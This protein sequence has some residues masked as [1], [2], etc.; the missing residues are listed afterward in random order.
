MDALGQE[1]KKDVVGCEK[2][3]ELQAS[4][5]PEMSEWGNPAGVIS[6]SSCSEYI[7]G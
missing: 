3:G 2:S 4:V 6:Q 1:A 5:D 7:G